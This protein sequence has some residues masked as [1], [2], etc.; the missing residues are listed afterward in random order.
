MEMKIKRVLSWTAFWV[1]SLCTNVRAFQPPAT[2]A[3]G[4]DLFEFGETIIT[5]PVGVV[6]ALAIV[7]YCVFHILKSH[8][9]GA[10]TCACAAL[11]LVKLEDIVYSLGATL[12]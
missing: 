4:Y 2:D 1:F 5:G 3:F 6:I 11:V 7:G 12:F 9:F 8:V 10:I